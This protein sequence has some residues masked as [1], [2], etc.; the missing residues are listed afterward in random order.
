MVAGKG[1]ILLPLEVDSATTLEDFYF[2]AE[3]RLLGEHLEGLLRESGGFSSTLIWGSRG[4]G[5]T[6]LLQG[7][8]LALEQQGREALLL[9]LAEVGA[10][11]AEMG[12]E[13]VR[14]VEL[15]CLD[16]V[17]LAE[18]RDSLAR[19]LVGLY[20]S[21]RRVGVRVLSSSHRAPVGLQRLLPDLHSRL[22]WGGSYR[23]EELEDADRATAIGMRTKRRRVNFQPQVVKYLLRHY[24]RDNRAL[25]GACQKLEQCALETRRNITINLARELLID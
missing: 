8:C 18:H 9:P 13:F 2:T 4:S 12:D 14:S 23:I 5:C 22:L 11:L 17:H 16:D 21:A 20:D 24:S 3:N 7:L 1:Q 10:Q 15:I 6:H 19:A 25:F